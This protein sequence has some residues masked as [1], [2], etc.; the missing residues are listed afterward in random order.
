[1]YVIKLT[2]RMSSLVTLYLENCLLMQS[3]M[4]NLAQETQKSKKRAQ[5]KM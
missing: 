4:P 5:A 1:M 3:P 2:L